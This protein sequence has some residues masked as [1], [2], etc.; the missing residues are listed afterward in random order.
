MGA[1]AERE[2]GGFRDGGNADVVKHGV[3]ATPTPCA[4]EVSVNRSVVE[5]L[6]ATNENWLG[7]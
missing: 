5:V 1:S 2:E 4:S 3:E 7:E 6:V